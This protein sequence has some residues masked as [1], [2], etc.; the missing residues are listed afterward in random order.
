MAEIL[1]ADSFV[2][3][4]KPDL[5]CAGHMLINESDNGFLELAN[6]LGISL[7]LAGREEVFDTQEA[8]ISH[9]ELT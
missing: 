2:C 4:K 3:H 9:N 1:R 6:R 8:C 5:Q 7:N